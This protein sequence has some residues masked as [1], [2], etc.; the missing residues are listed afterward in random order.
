MCP[1]AEFLL[2]VLAKGVLKYA[3]LSLPN[4]QPRANREC[5]LTVLSQLMTWLKE[6]ARFLID[7]QKDVLR[8]CPILNKHD[9]KLLNFRII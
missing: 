9:N 8:I 2:C 5:L 6:P 1:N 4:I 7:F 3:K